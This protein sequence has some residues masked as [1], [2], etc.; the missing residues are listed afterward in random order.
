MLQ[1]VTSP[2][3]SRF[4]STVSQELVPR[5]H[6]LVDALLLEGG[7]DV[8]VVDAGVGQGLHHGP[9]VVVVGSDLVADDLAVVLDGQER[10]LRHGVDGVLDDQV[11]DVH[12]VLVVRV[13][14]AGRRPQR[15][16]AV[17]PGRGQLVPAVAGEELLVGLVGEP[18]VG[19]PGLAEEVV[20]GAGLVQPVVDLGVDAGDEERRDRVDLGE[21]QPGVVRLLQTGEVGVH[22]AL[23]AVQP[24]DQGD[25][26]ADALAQGVGDR[27]GALGG[28][29]DLDEQVLPVDLLPQLLGRG[30]GRVGVEGEVGGDLDGDPAVDPVGGVVDRLEDVAGV[31]YVGGGQRE[32][33]LVDVGALGGELAH[34]VVVPLALGERG[35]EDRRVGGDAHDVVVPDE[36]GEVARLD[37][38]AGEVVE[39]DGDSGL[40]QLLQVV[41]HV[42]LLLGRVLVSVARHCLSRWPP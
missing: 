17:G 13:L 9:G 31:A 16:L 22:H 28:R 23:V 5:L 41:S 33:R 29:R 7:D 8:V 25:V 30:E 21:V 4:F 34:L 40:R 37:A 24:E 18:G 20:G 3:A 26:D 12:R 38:L 6:E 19:D 32:H 35:G 11:V 15:A 27:G 2:G 42:F 14:H 39:P 36:V 10:L 1:S